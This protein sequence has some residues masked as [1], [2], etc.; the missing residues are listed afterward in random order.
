[1]TDYEMVKK[2]LDDLGIEYSIEN[3]T[4]GMT[5][6]C[7]EGFEKVVAHYGFYVDWNFTH[8]GKFVDLWIAE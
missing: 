5:L 8:D 4:E 2:L 3:H 7:E 1:M 6:T